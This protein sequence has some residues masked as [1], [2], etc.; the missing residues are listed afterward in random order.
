M[1]GTSAAISNY[2]LVSCIKPLGPGDEKYA[3]TFVVPLD[4]PG[5][6]LSCRRP[7]AV[8][9]ASTFDYPLST[10]YDETDALVMFDDVVIPW[11][12][13]FLLRDL[14]GIRDQWHATGAHVLGNAQAP[15]RLAVKMRFVA[16]LARRITQIN[17]IERIPSVQEKLG[18][19]ASLAAIVEGM[20]VAAEA[21]S[22]PDEHGLVRPSGRYLYGGMGLQAEL[23]PRALGLLRELAGA[24]VLQVPSSFRDL[25][26]DEIGPD[27]RRYVRS[28]G[29]EAEDRIKLFKL[30]WDAVGSEFAGRHH[31]YEMFY[32][33]APFVAK[34]YAFRSYGYEEALDLVDT[35]LSGYDMPEEDGET[36]SK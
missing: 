13:V 26:S 18:D 23:Y 20:T 3:V 36:G 11:E 31:Q 15:I 25:T 21:E 35:V 10:R 1:L 32:A 30:A 28:P 34:G 27:I 5:V 33:G 24:G 7:Y 16:G 2:L 22:A 6:K 17:G 12:H 14:E 4:A 19:L 29:S 8:G 9:P